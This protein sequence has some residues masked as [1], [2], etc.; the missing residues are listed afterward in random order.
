MKS[1]YESRTIWLGIASIV[2]AI[3][4]AVAGGAG[5]QEAVLGAIGVSNV[6]LRTQTNQPL[7]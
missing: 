2:T 7:R 1:W 4:S 3:V 5:W 6:F